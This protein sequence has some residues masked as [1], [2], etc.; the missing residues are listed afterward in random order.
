M[1]DLARQIRDVR[2]QLEDA[3]DKQQESGS[4]AGAERLNHLAKAI[5]DQKV[6]PDLDDMAKTGL[7][8]NRPATD[9]ETLD[10]LAS[11]AAQG[12][13]TGK[14]TA[15]D[16]ANLIASLERSR[17]NL[18]RLAQ[19]AGASLPTPAGQT[20]TSHGQNPAQGKSGDQPDQGQQ[21]GQSQAQSQ[22]PGQG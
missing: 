22:Q 7:D 15:K 20:G 2:K 8:P 12:M 18:A 21:P 11:Q 6:A 9:A 14:A 13:T 19:Q 17:A 10:A 1:A 4:A 16:I 5:S 3:A